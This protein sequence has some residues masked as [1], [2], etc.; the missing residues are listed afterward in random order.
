MSFSTDLTSRADI[1]FSNLSQTAIDKIKTYALQGTSV[2]TGEIGDIGF[3]I[4][5]EAGKGRAWCNGET[6]SKDSYIDLWNFLIDNPNKYISK[7]ERDKQIAETGVCSSFALDINANLIYLPLIEDIYLKAGSEA[8]SG[9]KGEQSLPNI[10]GY[11]Q[12]GITWDKTNSNETGAL[13]HSSANNLYSATVDQTGNLYLNQNLNMDASRSSPIYQDDAD[14]EVNHLSLRAFVVIEAQKSPVTVINPCFFGYSFYSPVVPESNSFL[15]SD[16]AYHDGKVYSDMYKWILKKR[17]EQ[18]VQLY[19]YISSTNSKAWLK[20]QTPKVG[21][22]VY[23]ASPT[24]AV[25]TVSQVSGNTFTY[26]Y[27]HPLTGTTLATESLSPNS[28]DDKKVVIVKNNYTLD[29]SVDL[30]PKVLFNTE[31]PGNFEYFSDYDFI[32]NTTEQTFRLPLLDGSENI[33]GEGIL[34][35]VPEG[36]SEFR[37][38]VP[39]NCYIT[40]GATIVYEKNCFVDV[41]NTTTEERG[42]NWS[43]LSG[44]NNFEGVSAKRGDNVKLSY[45]NVTDNTPLN[46]VHFSYTKYKGNGSLYYY[47]GDTLSGFDEINVSELETKIGYINTSLDDKI[48]DLDDSVVHKTGNEEI[49]G[50]KTFYGSVSRK[51]SEIDVKVTPETSQINAIYYKDK[52][53][54]NIGAVET[55]KL[56]SGDVVTR[57]NA[58][59]GTTWG[60]TLGTGITMSGDI[61]SYAPIPSATSSTTSNRIATTGWVND[62]NSSTNVVHRSGNEK[63]NDVK[64]FTKDIWS[65]STSE[66]DTRAGF[67]KAKNL[68]FDRNETP[69]VNISTQFVTFDKNEQ[70][71]ALLQHALRTDGSTRI[72]MLARKKGEDVS[73]GLGAGYDANGNAFT[74]APTPAVSA[75]GTN[76][77]TCGYINSKFQYVTALPANPDANTFYFVKE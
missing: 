70:W 39:Y 53:N 61:Y 68:R 71:T 52:N 13:Y 36:S 25:G 57:L 8:T 35:S 27:I 32:I 19:G 47:V 14:V 55:L 24:T 73:T 51:S 54:I 23:G 63:I 76:I 30:T 66:S 1:D 12:R 64:R 34:S 46:V 45:K 17:E 11:I 40:L 20:S 60:G 31:I 41:Y 28:S 18:E 15:K 16:G 43:K 6:L 3:T 59:N 2:T 26:T 10:T 37:F 44:V 75:G 42:G 74:S 67:F 7:V 50:T 65:E 56:D 72:E 62:P 48:N 38:N 9:T 33:P 4:F 21:D 58:G 69:T 49:T 22:I 29:N 5:K 77:A